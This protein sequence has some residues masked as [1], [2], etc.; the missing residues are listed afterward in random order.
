LF[1]YFPN[2]FNKLVALKPPFFNEEGNI[3]FIENIKNNQNTKVNIQ[4]FDNLFI[5]DPIQKEIARNLC[6][7]L[8]FT[9]EKHIGFT[10]I[11]NVDGM[12]FELESSWV[13]YFSLINYTKLT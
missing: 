5:G 1:I 10:K 13:A 3:Y 11:K 2:L 8:L 4:E 6:K 7:K 9:N 12:P